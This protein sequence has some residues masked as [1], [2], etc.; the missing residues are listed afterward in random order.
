MKRWIAVL[1]LSAELAILA[2]A[3]VAS[4][5]P[6]SHELNAIAYI[7]GKRHLGCQLYPAGTCRTFIRV[8]TVS[9]AW[10]AFYIRQRGR[11]SKVQPDVASFHH[12]RRGWHVHQVGN[13]GGCDMPRAAKRDLNLFCF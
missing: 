4:R 8:S 9:P 1:F 12:G 5:P 6:T 3:A 10:A 7:A 2:P 13:G 11:H